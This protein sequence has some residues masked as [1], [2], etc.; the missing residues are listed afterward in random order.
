M[1]KGEH[2]LGM[3]LSQGH[4]RWFKIL[5][6]SENGLSKNWIVFIQPEQSG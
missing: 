2:K 5:D 1:F 3:N 6:F 4:I